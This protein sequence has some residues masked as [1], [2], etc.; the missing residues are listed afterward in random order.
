[1]CVCVCV[2]VCLCMYVCVC[3]CVCMCVCVCA[4]VRMCVCACACAHAYVQESEKKSQQCLMEK[5]QQES[6][7]V[8][9]QCDDKLRTLEE[10]QVS[11]PQRHLVSKERRT[12]KYIL[13]ETIQKRSKEE[14]Y[15]MKKKICWF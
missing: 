3:V 13:R 2:C 10:E 9:Q 1:M 14:N 11:M 4:H 12:R 8:K 15:G 7:H 5:H 6:I